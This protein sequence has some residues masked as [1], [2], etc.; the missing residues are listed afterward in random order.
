M[1]NIDKLMDSFHLE[2]KITQQHAED[3]KELLQIA[4]NQHTED[5][6]DEINKMEHRYGNTSMKEW[7]EY[8]HIRNNIRDKFINK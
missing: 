2:G 4:F 8:K 3:I 7:M 1:Q 6:V 5:I